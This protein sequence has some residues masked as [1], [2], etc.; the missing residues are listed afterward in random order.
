MRRAIAG[1]PEPAVHDGEAVMSAVP[2]AGTGQ[3][4]E[5]DPLRGV[6][7]H[8]R[9]FLLASLSER[10]VAGKSPNPLSDC[11]SLGQLFMLAAECENRFASCTCDLHTCIRHPCQHPVTSWW[12][13]V[14]GHSSPTCEDHHVAPL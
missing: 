8:H 5:E 13:D 7:G 1:H 3:V 4:Q 6:E 9:P 2:A 14:A 11:S 10:E 12:L